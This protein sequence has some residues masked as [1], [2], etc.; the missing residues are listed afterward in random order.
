MRSRR[1]LASAVLAGGMFA[2]GVGVSDVRPAE[3][4]G[5]ITISMLAV[6]NGQP[7]Y[8]VL[9]ANFERVYPNIT[10]DV[11]YAPTVAVLTQLETTELAAGNAPDILA[12][13]PGCGT[14]DL[15]LCAR[16]SRRPGA[17]DQGAVG[18]AV[19]PARHLAGQVRPGALRLRAAR[20]RPSASSRTTP[21]SR[22]LGLKVPQT[23]SQLL[24][25]CQKAKA[26]G[27][28]AVIL[29]G[30]DVTEVQYLVTE[31]AVATVYGKD[32]HWAAELKS[33]EGELRR[34]LGLA[35]GAPG[36]HRHEQ[37]G[38][39]RAGGRGDERILGGGAVR[40]GAGP[41]VRRPQRT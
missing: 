23:F 9:I 1:W 7:G 10:V 32:K 14:A 39:L 36:V 35:A 19:A 8:Q 18:E 11:T 41:D 12:T 37:R 3:G 16:A 40:T 4:N 2:L 13:Y 5:A 6:A 31:L 29:A 26:D 33:G 15:D 34:D 21:C 30:A 38:L 28:A 24:E 22:K 20:S 25:V 17:D 27:T